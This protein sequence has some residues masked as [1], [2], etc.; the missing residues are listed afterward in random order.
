MMDI[1]N[2]NIRTNSKTLGTGPRSAGL[3]AVVV[4]LLTALIAA[5]CGSSN[6]EQVPVPGAAVRVTGSTHAL[7]VGEM[8][9]L[10]ASTAGASDSTYTWSSLEPAVATVDA[11]GVVTAVA[12]GEAEIR[13]TG[14]ESGLSGEWAVVV[15]TVAIPGEPVVTVSGNPWVLVGD[16]LQLAATTAN[17]TDGSYTWTSS[18]D[19]VAS[20]S[21]NGLVS[22]HYD[23]NVVIA[24]TGA[25]TAASGT[26]ALVVSTT[27]PNYD[28]WVAS[29]HADKTAEPFNH[30]N[31]D[32]PPEIPTDCARCHST[33]GYRDYIGDDGTAPDVV[34][35]P[36]PIG[37]VIECGACHNPTASSLSHV[38]FPSGVEI[39]GLG[40]EARCMT[41]HQGRESTDSVDAKIAAAAPADDDTVTAGLSFSN[42]HYYA[43]GA[44]LN[45]GKVRGGYQFAGE[46]YD[47]RFRHVPGKDTCIGCHD[48]HSLKVK[49]NECANCHAGVSVLDDLKDIRMMSSLSND[50]DG[51]GDLSEGIYYEM[52]GQ[53]DKLLT[54]I[55]NYGAEHS[56]NGICYDPAAYPYWFIDTNSN[57]TCE[58][59]EAVNANKWVDWT[60]RLVRAT[61]NY[62]ASQKDPGAFA[63][64]AKYIM[65]LLYDSID[66]LNQGMT[67]DVDLSTSVR[68]DFGH[69]NGAGEPA[70]H[71]DANET[72]SGSCSRCH[73]GSDGLDFYLTYGV[74]VKGFV[75]LAAE[76]DNGLDCATCHTAFGTQPADFTTRIL[77]KIYYPSDITLTEAGEKDNVCEQCHVGRESKATV[78]AAIAPNPTST[79]LSFKNIHYLPASSIRKGSTAH[80]GYEYPSKVYAGEATNHELAGGCLFCHNPGLTQH[81]FLP[82]DN[83]TSC[84][85]SS[86]HGVTVPNIKLT[87]LSDY[88]GDGTV[89]ILGDEIQG[90]AARLLA[91][92]GTY[93]AGPPMSQ[94]VCYNGAAYP[95]FFKD[96]NGAPDGLCDATESVSANGAKFDAKGLRAA[97]NYQISQKEPGAWAHNFGYMAQI[98]IDSI[99]DLGGSLTGLVRP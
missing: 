18:D 76:Q 56:A 22:G 43:A 40:S 2:R 6:T 79:T 8:V 11:A 14:A 39:D 52:T 25:T 5:S 65:E 57:G 92:L 70:R 36:A 53:R 85:L 94:A 72:V 75:G 86:C 71:W 59:T 32:S 95:Y 46:T 82:E 9:S 63:H 17:G 3:A 73:G 88:D 20:V 15:S 35:N 96:N 62:Q 64:N 93:S 31:A 26:L 61:Y 60:A 55:Q 80:V 37:T 28:A 90:I 47:W 50:Y 97:F 12:E 83:T 77:D 42:I 99:E 87:H 41:C 69:F 34:D 24:A 16:T 48:P 38:I 21:A 19:T 66:H 49:I 30:W 68:N 4:L 91:A 54:A 10:S 81:T 51:D 44:T 58:A 78:D 98:L 89:E 7:L 23:G 45:A 33:P 1:S 29:A 74:G 67:N 27:I 84:G 13:A